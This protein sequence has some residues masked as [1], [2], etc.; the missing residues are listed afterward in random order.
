[1]QMNVLSTDLKKQVI[2]I[3]LLSYLHGD[4]LDQALQYWEE[5]YSYEPSYALNRFLNDICKTEHLKPLRRDMLKSIFVEINFLEKIE[6]IRNNIHTVLAN[7][8]EDRKLKQALSLML[9]GFL[10]QMPIQHIPTFKQEYYLRL[11]DVFDIEIEEKS[12][13]DM[14]EYTWL[15]KIDAVDFPEI[16]STLYHLYTARFGL[17]RA[18][19]VL[20]M[21]KLKAMKHYPDLHIDKLIQI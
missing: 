19:Q 15:N 1:M 13:N 10:Y 6:D 4:E 8:Q 12:E 9:D 14:Q 2:E 3:G 20:E 17:D 16:L 18:S 7:R 21:N 11:S 5:N